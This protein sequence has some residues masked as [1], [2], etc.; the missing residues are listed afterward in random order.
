MSGVNYTGNIFPHG[1]IDFSALYRGSDQKGCR[2]Q[3]GWKPVKS[4]SFLH[5]FGRSKRKA[6]LIT[7][8]DKA[9]CCRTLAKPDS[10]RPLSHR[11]KLSICYWRSEV[12]L[13]T[14][15]TACTRARPSKLAS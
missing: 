5:R 1:P 2:K 3:E 15:A 6:F 11:Y 12:C 10:E 14:G 13:R 4:R 8:A 9:L 7:N